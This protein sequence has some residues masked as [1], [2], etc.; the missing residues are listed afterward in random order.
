MHFW[1]FEAKNKIKSLNYDEQP[2]CTAKLSHKGDMIAY[3]LGNDWHIGPEGMNKWQP[4]LGVHII[5]DQ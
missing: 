4:K 5:T 3:G 1:D 2:I